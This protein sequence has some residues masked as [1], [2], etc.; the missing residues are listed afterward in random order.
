MANASDYFDLMRNHV[1]AAEANIPLTSR[2]ETSFALIDRL[3]GSD[4]AK[5]GMLM[6]D[7]AE[8]DI[9]QD[10]AALP[11]DLLWKADF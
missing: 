3:I 2:R 11:Q 8:F 10:L 1:A 4:T 7:D 6:D 9:Y 5:I